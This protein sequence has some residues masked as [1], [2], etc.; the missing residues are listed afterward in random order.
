M[1]LR[2]IYNF[3]L[4]V[5]VAALLALVVFMSGCQGAQGSIG[6]Q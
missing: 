6:K 2:Q 1:K 4:V 3:V 5:G